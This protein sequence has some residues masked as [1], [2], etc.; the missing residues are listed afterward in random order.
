MHVYVYLYVYM[1]IYI[2]IY[3]CIYIYMYIYIHN[4]NTHGVLWGAVSEDSS[5]SPKQSPA[6]VAGQAMSRGSVDGVGA[7]AFRWSRG[8][9]WNSAVPWEKHGDFHGISTQHMVKS[10]ENHREI[11]VE[12]WET[13]K[14][15][16]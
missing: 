16:R 5:A 14:N 6:V 7:E 12:S 2:C 10:W 8:L 1:Y 4:D 3:I 15:K 11:M 13:N 9:P